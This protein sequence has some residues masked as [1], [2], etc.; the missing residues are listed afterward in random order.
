MDE[1]KQAYKDAILNNIDNEDKAFYQK[2]V[3]NFNFDYLRQVGITPNLLATIAIGDFAS[4][5]EDQKELRKDK[6]GFTTK[7]EL[8]IL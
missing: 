2:E 4:D 5:D 1:Y 6:I 8:S 7:N 3:N